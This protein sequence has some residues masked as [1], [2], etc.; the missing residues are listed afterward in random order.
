MG[1]FT[2]EIY[3]P[4]Y[5]GDIVMAFRN[6]FLAL[7]KEMLNNKEV[8]DELA[9]STAL[10]VLIKNGKITCVGYFVFDCITGMSTLFSL[11]G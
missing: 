1:V 2:A 11:K 7:D 3:A 10:A 5:Q 8:R 6:C 4:F 9:G